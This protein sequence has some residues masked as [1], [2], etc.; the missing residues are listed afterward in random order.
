MSYEESNEEEELKMPSVINNYNKSNVVSD[1]DR[2]N[3]TKKDDKNFFDEDIDN[4]VK[5]TP[6]T[7]I[8]TKVVWSK[9]KPQA[10]YNDNANKIIE[11]ASYEKNVIENL[12]FLINLSIVTNNTKPTPEKLQT[13]NKAWNHPSEDTCKKW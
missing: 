7:T 9:K 5:A 6:K 1:S 4:E 3:D 12:N 2:D 8:N 10:S 11:Q 13:F